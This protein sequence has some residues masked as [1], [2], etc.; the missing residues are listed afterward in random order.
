MSNVLVQRAVRYALL[1]SASVSTALTSIGVLAQEQTDAAVDSLESVVVTGTRIKRQDYE[2]S[3]PVVTISADVFASAGT[4]QIESVLNELP[5]LVPSITTTSNNPSN[6]G[7][8]NLDLRGLGL[9][10]TLVLLDG[11][12]LVPSNASGV[13]DLNTIPT[14]LIESVEILTGGSSSVYGSDAIAGVVNVRTKRNFE[15]LSFRLR[16]GLTAES[17]GRTKLGELMLGGNFAD[18]RGN[19]VIALTFDT[20]DSLLAGERPFSVVQ[21]GP[22]LRPQGSTSTPEG[23]IAFAATNLPS[24]AAYT[25]LFGAGVQNNAA[26]GFNADGT[27]FSYTPV[28]NY[29]GN[30]NDPG[31]NP[32]NFSYNFA[33]VNY[34]Q[35]PLER[36]QL[37][38]F[39]RYTLNE[40]AEMY[41]R[42]MYTTYEAPQQLAPTPVSAG[43]GT[44]VPATNPLIPPQLR[45]L[46]NA[47]PN[48]AATFTLER[49]YSEAGPRIQLNDWE[50]SQALMGVRGDFS[51]RDQEWNWDVSASYGQVKGLQ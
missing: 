18:D 38:G 34:L 36:K 16:S 5:Q 46:L 43:V 14:G 32:D 50:S 12:R 7:Q 31:F 44:T 29:T 51:F 8:A 49:R 1:T 20:R 33:P 4:Q 24:Q 37:A 28:R 2:A 15:G 47:R 27:L 11:T 13:I 41:G 22:N 23:R 39:V 35:L 25:A 45:T 19:A 26:V 3:S 21:F 9:S 30:T 17:D 42:L 40:K 48:P 6:G 10:R